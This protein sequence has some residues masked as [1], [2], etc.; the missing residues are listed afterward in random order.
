V[1]RFLKRL[2]IL[3]FAIAPSLLYAQINT[4]SN[5]MTMDSTQLFSLKLDDPSLFFL[6]QL[7][8]SVGSVMHGQSGQLLGTLFQYFN[9]GIV[10]VAGFF[11]IWTTIKVVVSSS[12]E[13]SFMGKQTKGGSTVIRSV[14]GIGL[15]VPG[16]GGYSVIQI[17][18]MWTVLQ[19]CG[20]ANSVWNAA[21]NYIQ[22]NGTVFTAPTAQMAPLINVV[23]TVLEAEVCMYYSQQMEQNIQQDAKNQIAGGNSN[24]TFA[25]RAQNFPNF[26]PIWD[27]AAT[28]VSFPSERGNSPTDHGCGQIFWGQD[29]A[30]NSGYVETALRAV[31]TTDLASAAQRIANPTSS[32]NTMVPG[33][34]ADSPQITQLQS[35]VMTALVAAANDWYQYLGPL[36]V[37]NSSSSVQPAFFAQAQQQGW[38]YAGSYYY[39]LAKQ[40]RQMNDS[41]NMVNKL[42][43][44]APPACLPS[45]TGAMSFPLA[46]PYTGPCYTQKATYYV[47]SVGPVDFGTKYNQAS[48]YAAAATSVTMKLDQ[49][50]QTMMA[51][52]I[53]LDAGILN[54]LMSPMTAGVSLAATEIIQGTGDPIMKLQTA[55][56]V[57]ISMVIFVWVNLAVAFFFLGLVTNL[58]SSMQPVGFAVKDA[59]GIFIPIMMA[60]LMVLFV[61]GIM[62]AVYVPLIPA[63]IYIFTAIG[64]FVAVIEAMV[65]APLVALGITHPEGHDILGKAEQAV[66][67]ILGVFLR[68]VLMVIG[69]IA[70]MLLSIIALTLLNNAFTQVVA[71]SMGFGA[72]CGTFSIYC[73][74]VI[75]LVTQSYSLIYMV[76]DRGM[77][78]L[79]MGV[80]SGLAGQALQAAE[81]AQKNLA[82]A[83]ASGMSQG[84]SAALA[85]GNAGGGDGDGGGGQVSGKGGK[86]SGPKMGGHRAKAGAG[87]GEGEEGGGG[88]AGGGAGEAPGTPV[89]PASGGAAKTPKSVPK[90]WQRARDTGGGG[91]PGGTPPPDDAP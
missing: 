30:V 4:G 82:G 3:C 60:L 66:M 35:V 72:F 14:V 47:N 91:N 37:T 62:I 90:Y 7:F 55:G 2:L 84:M 20:F 52:D 67:L 27:V 75:Q 34:T 77:R 28:T 18:V 51:P 59:L 73:A 83:A 79:G 57:I 71:S 70:G 11:L 10:V 38:I 24:T 9:L 46:A 12:H 85:S 15:L 65:A 22:Q 44:T 33:L 23:G 40:Q 89:A 29:T 69:L 64:W 42:Q 78:W 8:G 31:V 54:V 16:T 17:F 87:A 26:Q 21:L 61:E 1:T 41:S 50:D 5:L 25:A 74:L 43:F 6:Q 48:Q 53:G 39:Q 76:P 45:T 13:G 32:D 56:N 68:P 63:I 81:G 19:G 88:E 49:A 86:G 36:R 58:M 80:E